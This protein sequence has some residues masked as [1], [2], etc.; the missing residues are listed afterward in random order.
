VNSPQRLPS[1]IRRAFGPTLSDAVE[2]ASIRLTA[3]E[4]PI[5]DSTTFVYLRPYATTAA[6]IRRR[7]L[8]SI[9]S[10]KTVW[11]QLQIPIADDEIVWMATSLISSRSE[12]SHDMT[13]AL[14]DLHPRMAAWALTSRWRAEELSDQTVECLSK[15]KV[16]SAASLARALLEGTLAFV[17]EGQA[18][19]TK[20][21]EMKMAGPP[22]PDEVL[23]FRELLGDLVSQAQL[24]SRHYP[25]PESRDYEVQEQFNRK[26]V[27][28]L[29][30][31]GAKVAGLDPDFVNDVYSQ[32]SD[33]AHPSYGSQSAYLTN[34]RIDPGEAEII[35]E[36]RRGRDAVPDP[37][38]PDVHRPDVAIAAARALRISV[39]LFAAAW[40]RFLAVVDDFGLTTEVSF[41]SRCGRRVNTGPAAPVEK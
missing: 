16:V 10:K 6:D 33:A 40:P 21:E 1:A 5:P 32:L 12:G 3:L 19:G 37:D 23:G 38:A 26:N 7:Q 30:T 2:N 29:I 39:E 25:P 18:M 41:R 24:A 36:L 13:V 34:S 28:T 22:G 9:E 17:G 14:L 31:K 4:P 8:A 35:W 20:W 27:L 15:W 11:H